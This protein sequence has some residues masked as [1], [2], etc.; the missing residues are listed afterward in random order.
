VGP[1]PEAALDLALEVEGLAELY[2]RALQVGE[3]VLLTG[4]QMAEALEGFKD[5]R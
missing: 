5:Y 2:W 4:E 1:S 3:P